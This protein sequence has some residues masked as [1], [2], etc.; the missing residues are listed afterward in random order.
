MDKMTLV[1][2]M[3]NAE[4]GDKFIYFTGSTREWYFHN[5]KDLK[6]YIQRKI[7]S[8]LYI[9]LQKKTDRHHKY[10]S[11]LL[12]VFEYMLVRR[13][14]RTDKWMKALAGAGFIE[15]KQFTS[16]EVNK[17]AERGHQDANE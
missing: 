12:T 8:G 16:S 14:K 4:A 6:D 9:P 11:D 7:K 1:K 10:K 15:H 17:Q 2:Q 5:D 13:E 3:R